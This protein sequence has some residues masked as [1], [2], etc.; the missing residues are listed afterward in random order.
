MWPKRIIFWLHFA[1]GVLINDVFCN[2]CKEDSEFSVS[3]N[4]FD[5]LLRFPHAEKWKIVHVNFPETPSDRNTVP[6]MFL[7]GGPTFEQLTKVQHFDL[8]NSGV[9]SLNVDCFRGMKSLETVNLSRNNLTSISLDAFKQSDQVRVRSLNLDSNQILDIDLNSVRMGDLRMLMLGNNRLT[10]FYIKSE[11]QYLPKLEVLDLEKNDIWRFGIESRTL[12]SLDLSYNCVKNFTKA[13]LNLPNLKHLY[14]T[15]N[16]LNVLNEDMLS[17]A[18]KLQNIYLSHNLLYSVSL[19]SLN[20]IYIDLNYNL[21]KTI[22]NIALKFVNHSSLHLSFNKVF[23]MTPRSSLGSLTELVCNFCNIHSIDPFFIHD[24][25]PNAE[26]VSLRSNLLRSAKLFESRSDDLKLIS[27]DLTYNQIKRIGRNT[28]KWLGKTINLYLANN[29]IHSIASGAFEKMINLHTLDLSN[30][31]IY[32]LSP[33]SFDQTPLSWLL[34]N[35]NNMAHFYIPG[36]NPQ[37]NEIEESNSMLNKIQLLNVENNPFQCDC[38]ELLHV[39]AQGK[40]FNLKVYDEKVKAGVKP[41]CIVNDQ[42]CRTDV[43]KDFVKD[44]W[45][46]FNDNKFQDI[47]LLDDYE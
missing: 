2:S 9:M 7:C 26:S 16:H 10:S 33:N 19:P 37:T 47:L 13:H 14:L 21:L 25:L 29:E 45:H 5:H 40:S 11:V 34:L 41:A 27:V 18:P 32:E 3:C 6:E 23:E 43:G 36:W 30:N 28:F 17:N 4:S 42:G 31:F 24:S 46:L 8:S 15:G 1:L 20:L 22:E 38:L 12:Q 35:G 44:Y 39:W